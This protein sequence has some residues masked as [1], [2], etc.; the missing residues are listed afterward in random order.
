[1]VKRCLSV[2]LLCCAL[3][4][5]ADNIVVWDF[6]TRDHQKTDV[7]ASLTDEFEEALADAGTYTVVERRNLARL[8]AVIAAEKALDVGS[9]GSNVTRGLKR[10]GVEVVVFGEVFDDINGGEVSVTV[11][12][13]DLAG[14]QRL[15][16]SV[17]MRRSLINDAASR[18]EK[19][20]TLVG[21]LTHQSDP[22]SRAAQTADAN[23]KP[24]SVEEDEF[25][26]D[27]KNCKRSG[28]DVVCH[29]KITNIGEERKLYVIFNSR[30]G[31]RFDDIQVRE[32]ITTLL[33]DEHNN[34]AVVVEAQLA[35]AEA[36]ANRKK[37]LGATLVPRYPT[38]ASIR[39][40]GVSSN[41]ALITR[42]DISCIATGRTLP[43]VISFENVPLK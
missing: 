19:M 18:R 32:K 7:T 20:A 25:V 29:F 3:P 26:F 31:T 33:Y 16:R 40:H 6:T 2:L 38:E 17:Q 42:M 37:G 12:F 27:L 22:A 43:F 14:R 41:A 30:N 28:Q 8:E 36:S 10:A 5:C 1:M 35:N 39:F 24:G 13:Q 34:E 4:V 23:V 11:R 9:F 15:I 21:L